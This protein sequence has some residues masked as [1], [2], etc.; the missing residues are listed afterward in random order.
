M[1][2]LCFHI[3]N[4]LNIRCDRLAGRRFDDDLHSTAQTHHQIKCQLFLDVGVGKSPAVFQLFSSKEQSLVIRKGAHLDLTL[5]FHI[6]Y[7]IAGI[8]IQ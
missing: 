8:D 4:G 2:N 6:V 3:I 1:L 5:R 7:S